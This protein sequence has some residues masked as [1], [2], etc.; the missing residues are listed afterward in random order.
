MKGLELAGAGK[1]QKGSDDTYVTPSVI[2]VP[3]VSDNDTNEVK[4]CINF[5]DL[6]MEK[7]VSG[8]NVETIEAFYTTI[9]ENPKT[10][11]MT[12]YTKAYLPF[13]KVIADLQDNKFRKCRSF[14]FDC[15]GFTLYTV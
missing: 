2:F 13:V 8:M 10:G 1:R 5:Q 12:A 6:A 11:N 7:F 15:K 3:T 4:A 14:T 9:L